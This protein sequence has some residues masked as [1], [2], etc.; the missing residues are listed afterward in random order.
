M[1]AQ[2]NEINPQQRSTTEG[3]KSR[4]KKIVDDIANDFLLLTVETPLLSAL[5]GAFQAVPIHSILLHTAQLFL[6]CREAE[7]VVDLESGSH[8]DSEVEN[9]PLA[10]RTFV[11]MAFDRVSFPGAQEMTI[12]Y[13]SLLSL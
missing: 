2:A 4:N 12:R 8:R 11:A 7:R 5:P 3:S 13:S 1:A 6:P 9:T 10:R